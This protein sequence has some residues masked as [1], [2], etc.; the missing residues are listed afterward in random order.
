MKKN[1]ILNSSEINTLLKNKRITI[2]RILDEQP[3][4][5]TING[6]LDMWARNLAVSCNRFDITENEV[7]NKIKQLEGK[8]FPLLSPNNSQYSPYSKYG[9]KGHLL[10]V[11][12]TW[13][14]IDNSLIYKANFENKKI[15]WKSASNMRE[16]YSRLFL[17]ID[18][19]SLNK[20]FLSKADIKKNRILSKENAKKFKEGYYWVWTIETSLKNNLLKN[21]L[22]ET[23][24]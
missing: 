5:G 11:Q 10:W 14:L 13:Q 7:K 16:E 18:N 17:L 2:K 3:K 22:Y 12:E 23:N 21:N 4:Q 9:K 8:I 19:I 1:I 24:K 15:K 20:E 6:S